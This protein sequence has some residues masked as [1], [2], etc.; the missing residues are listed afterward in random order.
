MFANT[1]KMRN[2]LLGSQDGKIIYA[3]AGTSIRIAV[4]DGVE[5]YPTFGWPT[6]RLGFIIAGGKQALTKS[7]ENAE[8]DIIDAKKQFMNLD[9]TKK[10]IIICLAA[11]GNTPFSCKV[12]EIANDKGVFTIGI[13]NNPRGKL[14]NHTKFKLILDTGSEVVAGSTRLKA[15]SA[16][17]ICLNMISTLLMIKL[18]RVKNGQMSHLVATNA[19]LRDRKKRII[20]L[21]T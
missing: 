18:G 11:S 8:D 12:A 6:K 7:V 1:E 19:K 10:D 15:G 20:D 9:V 16:Q 4:Q 17:K 21:I 3:G 5:L 14:L 2:I 13:S